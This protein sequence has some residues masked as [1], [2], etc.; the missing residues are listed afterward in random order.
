MSNKGKKMK[1]TQKQLITRLERELNETKNELKEYKELCSNLNEEILEIQQR[2]DEV[3]LIVL[4]MC[5]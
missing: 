4:T 3:F 5:K 1:E 2:A